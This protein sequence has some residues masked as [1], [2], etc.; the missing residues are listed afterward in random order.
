[1]KSKIKIL[2]GVSPALFLALFVGFTPASAQPADE[3]PRTDNSTSRSA[4]MN[5]LGAPLKG[6]DLIG[7]KIENADGKKIGTLD[8]FAVDLQAG[9]IVQVIV[10][11]GGFMNMGERRYAVPPSLVS[12]VGSGKPLRSDLTM[13]RLKSAPAFET[14][15]WSEFYGS[16]LARESSRYFGDESVF[17]SAPA[18]S[19]QAAEMTAGPGG[20]GFVEKISKLIGLSVKN[21]QDEKIGSVDNLIVDL[22]SGRVVAVIVSTGGFLG[23][24]DA[25][26][27][28]PPTALRY[29]AE[30]DALRLDTTKE[31][32]N[33]APRFKAGE[34]PDFARPEYAAGIYTA[35][36]MQPYFD[37]PKN[38]AAAPDNAARNIRDRD[39]RNLTAADQSSSPGDIEI[40]QR[41]RREVTAVEGLSVNAKNVKIIT[42]NGRVTLR[43]P[44][45]TSAEKTQVAEIAVRIARME[46]VDDQ[47]EVTER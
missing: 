31:A 26:S 13:E 10:T 17:G 29:T 1:M 12:V 11:T 47:L 3:S 5:L 25:L 45:K 16:T 37:S 38:T 9:R 27:A 41:I 23:M 20:S 35:Y 32:L 4:R 21:L 36:G 18:R 34:W 24:G 30:H 46:N 7:A 28:V 44:V 14:A 33:D 39:S 43:G 42:V 22:A 40:T 8:E 19:G 15:R 6:S 2:P